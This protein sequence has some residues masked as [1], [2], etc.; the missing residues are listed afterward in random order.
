MPER[1]LQKM[2]RVKIALRQVFQT[3]EDTFEHASNFSTPFP[4]VKQIHVAGNTG[5]RVPMLLFRYDI[6]IHSNSSAAVGGSC[7]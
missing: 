2:H 4:V 3:H 6:Q 1:D 7:S 5:F